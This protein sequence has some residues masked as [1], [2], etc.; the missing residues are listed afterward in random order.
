MARRQQQPKRDKLEALLRQGRHYAE[1]N[2]R[3]YGRI[4][5]S[6]MALNR[7]GI[8]LMVPPR[9]ATEKDKDDFSNAAR[10]LAVGYGARS[11]VRVSNTRRSLCRVV[12]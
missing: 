4:P 12:A 9:M 8:M 2:L 5:P 11:W 3:N 6:A 1:W 7:D 10:M